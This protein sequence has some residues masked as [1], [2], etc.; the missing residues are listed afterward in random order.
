V[1]NTTS[2]GLSDL[3]GMSLQEVE[4]RRTQYKAMPVG[5]RLCPYCSS[6]VPVASGTYYCDGNHQTAFNSIVKSLKSSGGTVS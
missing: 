5:Q 4:I 6:K 3:K 2:S 1:K